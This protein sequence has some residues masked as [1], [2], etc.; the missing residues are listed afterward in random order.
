[1]I[2]IRVD[3]RPDL[4]TLRSLMASAWGTPTDADFEAIWARSL[5]HLA[6]YDG[7]RLVGYVNVASD[8]GIHA[9][10]FDT[11]VDPDYRRQGIGTRLVVEAAAIAR[12]RGAQC[13]HVDFEPSLAA[14]YAACGF[15]PTA[16]GL[17]RLT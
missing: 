12:S 6:A 16:A 2:T 5:A 14:F 10:V 9:S 1:M 13:L 3:C 17:M 7:E 4:V 15:L 11:T 8:G